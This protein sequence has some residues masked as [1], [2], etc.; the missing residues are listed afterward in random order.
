MKK[1]I[2][3]LLMIFVFLF[4]TNVKAAT[5]KDI[6]TYVNEKQAI[7]CDKSTQQLFNTYRLLFTRMLKEKDLSNKDLDKIMS[8]LKNALSLIE[9]NDVCKETDLKKIPSSVRSKIKNYLYDGMMIIYDAPA[10]AAGTDTSIKVPNQ[11]DNGIVIDKNNNTIDIYQGGSLYDKVDLSKRTFNYVGPN[12][13]ILTSLI[14]LSCLLSTSI[15]T[16]YVIRK[17]TFKWKRLVMDVCLPMIILTFLAIPSIYYFRK[18]ISKFLQLSSMLKQPKTSFVKKDIIVTDDH[19][20]ISYPS[21]GS[22]YGTLKIPSLSIEVPIKFGDSKDILVNS[23]GH[24]TTSFFPGEGGTILYSGHN[25][26]AILGDMKNIKVGTEIV[27]ETSYGVFAY[28]VEKTKIMNVDD[29]DEIIIT[30]KKEQLILYTCYPFSDILYGN[31]RFVVTSKLISADW[32][33]N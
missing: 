33:K 13:V 23:I 4:P 31:Q 28:N 8:N 19:E 17:K 16:Y 18:P 27:I 15:I 1:F 7:I 3:L 21:Y 25:S 2:L 6:I 20:I 26:E 9:K 10:A 14:L 12:P 24:S 22:D 32:R 30:Y 11:G 29:Y 5:K